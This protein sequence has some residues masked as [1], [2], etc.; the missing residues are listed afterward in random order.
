MLHNY[1]FKVWKGSSW[2]CHL[3]DGTRLGR[4]WN[5][6][7]HWG[8]SALGLEKLKWRK[9]GKP[10]MV[11]GEHTV[12]PLMLITYP[13]KNRLHSYDL[14]MRPS[15]L[16]VMLGTLGR[17]WCSDWWLLQM[18]PSQ[19]TTEKRCSRHGRVSCWEFLAQLRAIKAKS[20]AWK[21]TRK[22]AWRGYSHDC[23]WAGICFEVHSAAQSAQKCSRNEA[24]SEDVGGDPYRNESCS[25]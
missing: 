2:S 25:P 7:I 17:S 11:Q 19:W 14:P 1:L 24:V 8:S 12:V 16:L 20:A 6:R 22:V 18:Q 5:W 10:R 9:L 4:N 13:K 23:S 15:L 21:R 3:R